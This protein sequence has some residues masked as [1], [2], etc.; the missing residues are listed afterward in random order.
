MEMAE[1]WYNCKEAVGLGDWA[2][3]EVESID[4]LP[5]WGLTKKPLYQLEAMRRIEINHNLTS[6]ELEYMRMGRFVQMHANGN[7]MLFDDFCEKQNW[8]LKQCINNADIEVM[9]RKSRHLHAASRCAKIVLGYKG[10]SHLC[11]IL[12][13]DD[14]CMLYLFFSK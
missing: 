5:I 9:I 14:I 3:L 2:I 7:F 12:A 8:A 10:K 6:E 11:P 1:R 4:W 13:T